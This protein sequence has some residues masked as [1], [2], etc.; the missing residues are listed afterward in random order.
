MD[1]VVKFCVSHEI[2]KSAPTLGY[3]AGNAQFTFD[4]SYMEAVKAKNG[5]Q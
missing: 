3:A 2:V 5:G 4:S 1:R